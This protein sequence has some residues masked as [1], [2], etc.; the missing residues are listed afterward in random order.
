MNFNLSTETAAGQTIPFDKR[1]FGPAFEKPC[2]NRA[3][4]ICVA[5]KC[6]I[7]YACQWRGEA[8]E[9]SPPPYREQQKARGINGNGMGMPLAMAAKTWPTPSASEPRQGFQRRPEGMAP[10]QNQQSLSTVA[11]RWPTP[12]RSEQ[13]W[14][15]PRVERGAYTRDKGNPDSPRMTLEGQAI[16]GIFPPGPSEL[17]AWRT[18]L[19]R[20]P[21]LD[22]ALRRMADGLAFR[23]DALRMLGNG[24]V[25]LEAAYAIRTLVTRL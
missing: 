15:T 16:S 2:R 22:P 8:T 5:E 21:Q 3:T 1:R 19:G 17:D 23:V 7:A 14:M 9:K 24:V 10:E 4:I 12:G 6:R 13:Q 25:P 11:M 20:A 18:I